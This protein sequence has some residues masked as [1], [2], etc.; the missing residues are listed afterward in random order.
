MDLPKIE[1]SPMTLEENIE[2][3]KWAFFED[4]KDLNVHNYTIQYFPELSIIDL[5]SKKEEAYKIIRDVVTK[6]YK[7]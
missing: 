7:K 4:T 2:I 3:I 1:F 5:N 6:Y